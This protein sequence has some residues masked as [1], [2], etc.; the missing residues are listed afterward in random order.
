MTV[1][2]KKFM[3]DSQ[4]YGGDILGPQRDRNNTTVNGR[5]TSVISSE[6]LHDISILSVITFPINWTK[7][8][9]GKQDCH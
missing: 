1:P 8:K 5:G 3:N 6:G 9:G 4:R 7:N 2:L